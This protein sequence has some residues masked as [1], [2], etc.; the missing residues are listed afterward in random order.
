MFIKLKKQINKVT[1]IGSNEVR[2]FRNNNGNIQIGKLEINSE[3]D[4]DFYLIEKDEH[5]SELIEIYSHNYSDSDRFLIKEDIELLAKSDNN[6]KFILVSNSCN[7]ILTYYKENSI[8]GDDFIYEIE[9]I[10]KKQIKENK[11]NAIKKK[12]GSKKK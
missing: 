2:I 7:T 11:K 9:K 4:F 1:E 8:D 3:I 6:N 10:I 12:K 5:F